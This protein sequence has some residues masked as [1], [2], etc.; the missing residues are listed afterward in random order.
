MV[1]LAISTA[2]SSVANDSTVTVGPNASSV[3]AEEPRETS[4]ITV[5]R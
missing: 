4:S 3:T 2:S 5:G 1:S